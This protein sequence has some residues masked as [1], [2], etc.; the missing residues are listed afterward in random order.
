MHAYVYCLYS[1]KKNLS[2][3]RDLKKKKSFSIIEHFTRGIRVLLHVYNTGKDDW[4]YGLMVT[5]L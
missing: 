4:K 5:T 2:N 3:K 1:S